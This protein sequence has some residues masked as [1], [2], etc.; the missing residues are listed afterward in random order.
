MSDERERAH[1]QEIEGLNLQIDLLRRR[2]QGLRAILQRA[3]GTR[4]EARKVLAEKRGGMLRRP[5]Q[6]LLDTLDAIER[7]FDGLV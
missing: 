7:E 6:E 2:V 4:R 1:Q 5:A 3:E